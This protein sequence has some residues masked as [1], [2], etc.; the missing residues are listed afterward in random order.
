MA[1]DFLSDRI[2]DLP[3]D[4]DN[5]DI[6]PEY[7]DFLQDVSLVDEKAIGTSEYRTFLTRTLDWELGKVTLQRLR[8]S[9]AV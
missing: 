4:H 5:R 1:D 7:Y 8:T 2:T 6:T 9:H 3:T